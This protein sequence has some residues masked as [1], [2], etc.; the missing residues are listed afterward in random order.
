MIQSSIVH[1]SL[2]ATKLK[3]NKKKEEKKKK[4]LGGE[5]EKGEKSG[6]FG[7]RF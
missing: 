5:S 2:R 4:K 7:S 6:D 3:Q 1:P